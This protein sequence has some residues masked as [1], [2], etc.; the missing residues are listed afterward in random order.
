MTND[1]NPFDAL[2][3]MM[4]HQLHPDADLNAKTM[5]CGKCGAAISLKEAVPLSYYD[6]DKKNRSIYICMKCFADY[7][8]KKEMCDREFI[9]RFLRGEI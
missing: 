6:E 8:P 4:L 2:K 3:D 1:F 9:T 7:V 5:L